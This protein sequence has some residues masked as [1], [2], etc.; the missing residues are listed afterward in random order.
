VEPSQTGPHKAA[1]ILTR[2]IPPDQWSVYA[3]VITEAARRNIRFAVGGG[4]ATSAY[5][6]ILRNTK[7]MD[8]FV[9]E[10]E[11][12]ELLEMTRQLGFEE[13]KEVPYDRTWSY[14]GSRQGVIIDFLWNMLNGRS[15]VDETWVAEGWEVPVRGVKV[16][17]LPVE[18]LIWS[19]LYIMKSDRTDWPDILNL[20]YARGADLDW[21]RLL[22]NLGND[23]LL[24]GGVLSLF[25]WL[26]PGRAWKLPEFIWSRM[27]LLPPLPSDLDVDR[28]RVALLGNEHW[29]GGEQP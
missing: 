16:M 23:R 27:G 1:E 9:M 28:S 7:D 29:F 4:L 10:K 18:E 6:G 12:E 25:R 19:K 11:S 21:E 24:L 22:K 14:R 20:V 3:T 17:L 13:Y 2:L 15:P 5:S 26:C 8:I